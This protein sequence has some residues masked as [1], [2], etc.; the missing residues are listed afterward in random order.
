[1][2]SSQSRW[3]SHIFPLNQFDTRKYI[4]KYF[5]KITCNAL[6]SVARSLKPKLDR[7]PIE[8]VVYCKTEAGRI[9]DDGNDNDDEES[10]EEDMMRTVNGQFKN[11][12]GFRASS[13]A[14]S[15]ASFMEKYIMP[16]IRRFLLKDASQDHNYA[17]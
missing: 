1:M 11:E 9:E 7:T 10:E 14:T 8:A 3:F 17:M 2:K 12:K 16:S 5:D 13:A 15:E 6:K 4:T